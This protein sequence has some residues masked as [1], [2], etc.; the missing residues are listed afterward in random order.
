MGVIS[1]LAAQLGQMVMVLVL[2]P[3]VIG[4]IRKIKARL[5]RR[6]GPPIVQPYRDLKRLLGKEVVLADNT[7]WLFRGVP[8]L[9]VAATWW[10]LPLFFN[11]G[12]FGKWHP[13][14]P[15]AVTSKGPQRRTR[16]CRASSWLG[17]APALI[18]RI[19]VRESGGRSRS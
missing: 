12:P 2:A 8:Y 6:I 15:N 18:R 19:S 10:Q 11:R 4:L 9:I 17:H 14:V 5:Q 13:Y 3:A 1:A 7:S 16:G